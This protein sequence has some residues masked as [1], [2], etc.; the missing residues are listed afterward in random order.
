MAKTSASV[1]PNVGE[2]RLTIGRLGNL[3][4]AELRRV[5]ILLAGAFREATEQ[6]NLRDG[7]ISSLALI[8]NNPG[9]SQNDISRQIDMDKSVVVAVIDTLEDLGWAIRVKSKEDRRRHALHATPEGIAHL[10]QLATA[11][12]EIEA[13]MLALVSSEDL[14]TLRAILRRIYLSC[15]RNENSGS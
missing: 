10:D 9:I 3:I 15:T 7:V 14:E 6:A 2:G 13:D 1:R 4:T 8:A 11:V 12:E 5:D